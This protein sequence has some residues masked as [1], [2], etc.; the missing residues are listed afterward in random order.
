MDEKDA[1]IADLEFKLDIAR[2]ATPANVSAAEVAAAMLALDNR[3][4]RLRAVAKATQAIE[5]SSGQGESPC[6]ADECPICSTHRAYIA[7]KEGDIDA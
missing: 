6:C 3:I 7:L 2:Q 1:R 4:E 5:C